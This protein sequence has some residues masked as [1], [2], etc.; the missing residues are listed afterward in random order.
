[1]VEIILPAIPFFVLFIARRDRL[2]WFAAGR[3]RAAATRSRGH[4]DEHRHGA[5]QRRHGRRLQGRLARWSTPRLYALTPLRLDPRHWWSGCCCSSPTTSCYYWFHRV[6]P[7]GAAALGQPRGAPLRQYFNLSTALRQTWTPFDGLPF[8]APL[9]LLGVP[10]WMIFLQQSVSLLYQFWMHTERD[11]AAAAAGR[12]GASTRPRTTACTTASNAQYLDRNYGGI[13]IIWDRLF[14]TFEPEGERV[15]YGLTKNIAHAQPAEGGDPRV[16]RD[17]ARRA[18]RRP[19]AR[20]G[21]LRLA[22]ARLDAL[23]RLSEWPVSAP[24]SRP[25]GDGR[26]VRASCASASW[27]RAARR[28]TPSQRSGSGSH[29]RERWPTQGSRV[30]SLAVPVSRS[31]SVRPARLV[32]ATPSPT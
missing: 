1:M 6:A 14:G 29:R 25:R 23:R 8:W 17:L 22:R 19:L 28:S 15:V 18:R 2:L 30:S 7:R 27:P 10:P 11:R 9:A 31:A 26:P 13:L 21:R 3:R 12:V 16:R 24:S 5:R 4:R 32:V 20:P